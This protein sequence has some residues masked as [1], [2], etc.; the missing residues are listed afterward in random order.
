MV[1]TL[2]EIE[3]ATKI[4]QDDAE[5][6]V[7]RKLYMLLLLDFFNL[8]NMTYWTTSIEPP[9]ASGSF[10]VIGYLLLLRGG[11]LLYQVLGDMADKHGPAFILR[12]G[13]RGMLVVSTCEVAKECFTI[14]DKALSSRPA[15]AAARHLGYNMAM[16]G[17]APYGS[18]WHSLHKI[19][20]TELLSNARLDM[21]KH[22]MS[23][24]IGTSLN[25]LHTHCVCNDNNSP[26]VK[27]DMMKW[28]GDLNFNIVL[29]MVAGK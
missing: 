21:L 25:E 9:Q 13:S 24:E 14:N 27:V 10:P 23:G 19:S 18:Y 16:F 22:V 7:S 1:A 15:N 29:Q 8:Y 12:L 5:M 11:R 3:I 4:L 2:G 28:F 26:P 20:T 17:F 6:Q